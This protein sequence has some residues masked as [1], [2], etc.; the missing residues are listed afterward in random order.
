MSVLEAEVA[1]I[2]S[3]AGGATV[4]RE[5][6]RA[7]R[8]VVLL[9]KGQAKDRML[10][11]HLAAASVADRAGM[12]FSDEYLQ[13]VRGVALGGSTLL[14]CGT[15]TEPVAWLKDE[16]EIDLS[17]ELAE[18]R[19]ELGV[20]RLPERLLG[21]SS[22]RMLDA[23]GRLG[24][25]WEIFEKFI[26]AD[27]C[28]EGCSRCM[29]VCPRGAKWT[30]RRFAEEAVTHGAVLR[31]GAA[32]RRILH[33]D[34]ITRGV[35]A[36]VG[37]EALEVRA[38]VVVLSAGGMGS[39]PLLR[40]AGLRAGEGL[41]VDPLVVTYGRYTGPGKRMGSAFCPPMSVGTWE[42]ADEGF[43]LS[44]LLEPW[45]L[46][47][48]HLALRR[49]WYA[50]KVARYDRVFGIMTKIRDDMSGEL[51]ADGRFSKPLTQ[52]DRDKLAA[53][54][55]VAREVLVEAGCDPRSLATTRPIGAHP[56]GGCRIGAVVGRDLQT[57]VEGLYVCDASVFPKA[58]G[59][60]VV[61]TAVCMAKRLGRQL[62]D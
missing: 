44:P 25:R 42:F 22:R 8:R 41:F 39:A 45:L 11:T 16:L 36:S 9:E 5:L 53:G 18:A 47:M 14:T 54:D 57:E 4:A 3:G 40:Q 10:G 21:D 1:V 43:M 23:A 60:P 20:S 6:A 17:D 34:G 31:T 55:R 56:G 12:T 29:L 49:P 62:L 59:T 58:L 48:A 32:V 61:L 46:F 7:G 38:P 50:A 51:R 28:K 13:V 35:E 2:G 19:K 30:A 37:G 33:R 52:A 27:R 15:A 26:D 24:F